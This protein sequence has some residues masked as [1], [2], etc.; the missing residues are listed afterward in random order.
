MIICLVMGAAALSQSWGELN[1]KVM[2]LTGQ[3]AYAEA[4]PIARRA[5]QLAKQQFGK[6]DEYAASLNNLST[7]YRNTDSLEAAEKLMKECI[8]IMKELPSASPTDYLIG[9]DNL[10]LVY[11]CQNKYSQ[12]EKVLLE[13]ADLSESNRDEGYMDI[14]D[15]LAILYQESGEPKK[16]ESV[17][18]KKAARHLRIS[19]I[20]DSTYGMIITPLANFY[21]ATKKLRLAD[22]LFNE[23]K[24][25][26]EVYYGDTSQLYASWLGNT[27]LL[28][29]HMGRYSEAEEMLKRSLEM[30]VSYGKLNEPYAVGLVNLGMLYAE[31]KKFDKASLIYEESNGLIRELFGDSSKEYVT[32]L[33]N[34]ASLYKGMEEYEK[35]E[36]I[37]LKARLISESLKQPNSVGYIQVLH[38]IGELYI[39]M[40]RYA[41][42][43]KYLLEEFQT[44]IKVFGKEDSYYS[45]CLNALANLY[46]EMGQVN[47]SVEYFVEAINITRTTLGENSLEYATALN[48]LAVATDVAEVKEWAYLAAIKIVENLSGTD[49]AGYLNKSGN[50]GISYLDDKEYEKAEKLLLKAKEISLKLN[51]DASIDFAF[52]CLQLGKCYQGQQNFNK[53]KELLLQALEIAGKKT[54]QKGIGYEKYLTACADLYVD[55]LDYK[56]AIYYLKEANA[57]L[58]KSLTSNLSVLSE[59]EKL[60]YIDDNTFNFSWMNSMLFN[61]KTINDPVNTNNYDHLLML[62]SLSLTDSKN[63]L[64]I[65]R[66]SGDSVVRDIYNTWLFGKAKLARQYGLPENERSP[67][68]KTLEQNVESLEKEL[69]R[70]SF[71]FNNMQKNILITTKDIQKSMDEDEVA[72]EFVRFYYF[73]SSFKDSSIYAAYLL[74]KNDSVPYFIPLCSEKQLA[75]LSGNSN[76][77]AKTID[78]LYR[79]VVKL[80][81]QTANG[82]ELYK[83]LWLPLEPYLKGIKKITYSPAGMLYNIAFH[84]LP[85]DSNHVLMERYE[86]HQCTSTRGIALR[87]NERSY[88][89]SN[90][91]LFGDPEFTSQRPYQ[92]DNPGKSLTAASFKYVLSKTRGNET[93]LWQPLPGTGNEVDIIEK[94]LKKQS[95]QTIVYKKVNASEENAK[96]ISGTPAGIVHFATHGFYL[97]D[98]ND[99]IVV[100]KGRRKTS[101]ELSADPLWRSGLVLAGANV[102]WSGSSVKNGAEDGVLTAY[103]ISQLDLSN[104]ELVVLSACETGLGEITESEGVFG[105]QRA[106]KIAGA[107][108]MLISLWP[109]PDKETAEMMS[110][111]YSNLIAE[112]NIAGAFN[113]ARIAMKQKYNTAYWAAFTLIE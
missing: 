89:V 73:D 24:N 77:E 31:M 65:V 30:K 93:G 105:L 52:R 63:M 6:S 41:E 58:L 27:G 108:K 43:E 2:E 112:K 62:K 53:A 85:A 28:Y 19:G 104:T 99:S 80:N 79:G 5:L 82:K 10:A 84:A 75:K 16:E 97:P 107:R 47:K 26:V 3:E 67:E 86:L 36:A 34:E 1:E 106:F 46:S 96:K 29:T 48:N 42:A 38:Q 102:I 23:I 111:F 101:F 49:N 12:A 8:S 61:L 60:N 39:D 54:G 44:V 14:M 21:L 66:N 18:L 72:I 90:A 68:L 35:A 59:K 51:G 81:G 69:G 100:K 25:I 109:V 71:A 95:V 83:L 98:P 4:I 91:V 50:L 110:L 20:K 88:N 57:I 78:A 56:T 33:M 113:K 22:S 64:D 37:S 32:Q 76:K 55:M 94:L 11:W 40:G 70:R 103:E 9:L 7:L 15:K 13:M 74:N 45:Y 17:Y 87:E 92:A